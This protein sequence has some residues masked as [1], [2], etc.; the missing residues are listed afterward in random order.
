MKKLI[1]RKLLKDYISFFLIALISS[2]LIIWV[3]QAVNFLDIMIEDGREYTVYIN[4]SLLNFPKIISRLFPFVLFFSIFYILSKYELNNELMIFW[5]F[6][7][8]KIKF[9]NFI[10][11]IS[12]FLFIVQ[13]L[14]T[15]II[16]PTSQDKARSFLRESQVN[17]LGNFV[18]PK[19]FNDTIDGVTIYAE[20][21]DI[22]GYLYN[23]YI[24]KEFNNE[25]EIT[26]ANKGKFEESKGVPILILYNGETL[27][28]KNNKITNFKFSKSDF[29]LKNLKANTIT[30]QKNQE[31]KTSEII[32]CIISIY[33]LKL[34][35]ITRKIEEITNCESDNRLNLLKEI[36][37]RLVIPFYIPILMLIPYFLILSSKEKKNYSKLKII[38]FITGVITIILSQGFIRFLSVEFFDNLFIFF[39]PIVLLF[40]LY[41]FFILKLNFRSL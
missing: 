40:I 33:N 10:I 29:L 12:V 24:K 2:S 26:Y 28:N 18:K 19:R 25:F 37:K 5:N 16:V 34:N 15:S 11:F 30:Q 22:N 1:Y 14:F 6:G 3:F 35:I 23:L 27:I 20:S 7:E 38:T 17:F 4:Y 39:A 36:Y 21:K 31:M 41:F 13:V 8:Q 32:E 9:V